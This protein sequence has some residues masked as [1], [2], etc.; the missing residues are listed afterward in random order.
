[1]KA[2]GKLTKRNKAGKKYNTLKCVSGHNAD[3]ND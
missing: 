3:Y 1:M 2:T